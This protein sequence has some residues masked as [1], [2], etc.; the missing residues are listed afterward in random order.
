MYRCQFRYIYD[1]CFTFRYGRPIHML[2]V[3]LLF[4]NEITIISK[5]P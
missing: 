3:K 1:K 5:W 4:L 2:K